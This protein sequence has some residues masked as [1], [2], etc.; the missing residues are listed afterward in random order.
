MRLQ[1]AWDAGKLAD[2]RTFSTPEMFA[3]LKVDFEAR[4]DRDETDVVQLNAELV[5]LAEDANEY[6]ASVRYTGLLREGSGAA[7]QPFAETWQL[8][9][10]KHGDDGWLLA[11]IEQTAH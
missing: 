2:I 6:V 5:D 7:A 9:K 1:A 8:T 11:G 10:T 4:G 3:E